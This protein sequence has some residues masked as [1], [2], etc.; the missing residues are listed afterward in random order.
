MMIHNKHP[1]NTYH[2]VLFLCSGSRTS[3]R[4]KGL[5]QEY[6]DAINYSPEINHRMDTYINATHQQ[7][8]GLYQQTCGGPRHRREVPPPRQ[9]HE[10]LIDFKQLP[11]YD[12]YKV[13]QE[14][15]KLSEHFVCLI[16]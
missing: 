3:S 9:I 10:P 15:T 1:N 7:Q 5:P 16:L 2:F 14:P 11:F 8:Q 13:I 4:S 6:I 12:L